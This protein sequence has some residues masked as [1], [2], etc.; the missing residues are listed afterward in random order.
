MEREK[1]LKCKYRKY[2]RQNQNNKQT[3]KTQTESYEESTKPRADSLSKI[4]KMDKFLAKLTKG[5]RARVQINKIRKEKEDL[6]T[7]LARGK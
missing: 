4:T 2:R 1:H 6:A 7:D 3:N 5:H